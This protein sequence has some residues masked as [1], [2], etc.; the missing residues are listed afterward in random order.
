MSLLLIHFLK[1]LHCAFFRSLFFTSDFQEAAMENDY[2][3]KLHKSSENDMFL[4]SRLFIL[5]LLEIVIFSF[6]IKFLLY[7]QRDL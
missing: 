4:I 7:L 3:E 1:V 2:F 5:L 6:P